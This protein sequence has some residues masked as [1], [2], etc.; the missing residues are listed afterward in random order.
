VLSAKRSSRELFPTP[1][2]SK[3]ALRNAEGGYAKREKCYSLSEYDENSAL[4]LW[5]TLHFGG[6]IVTEMSSGQQIIHR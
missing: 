4:G 3:L 6:C 2:N 1:E 5:S